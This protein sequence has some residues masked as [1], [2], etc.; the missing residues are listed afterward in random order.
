M[1]ECTINHVFRE[2]NSVAN[3]LAKHGCI[4]T[5]SFTAFH[6]PPSFVLNTFHKDLIGT[7]YLRCTCTQYFAFNE[8]TLV[9]STLSPT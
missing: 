9:S 3:L 6:V 5:A 2:T 1:L 8:S 4:A 7:M